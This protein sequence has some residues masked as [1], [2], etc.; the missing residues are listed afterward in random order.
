MNFELDEDQTMIEATVE[1]FVSDRYPPGVRE[2]ATKARADENWSLLAEL[3]ILAGLFSPEDGGL[4]GGS[5]EI[6]IILKTLGRGLVVE[7][8]LEQGLLAGGILAAG[9][10]EA[11][12]AEWLSPLLAGERRLGVAFTEPGGRWSLEPVET[13][14]EDARVNGTKSFASGDV[15]GWIVS[16]LDNRTPV[17]GLVRADDVGVTQRSY[18]RVDGAILAEIKFENAAVDRLPGALSSVEDALDRARLGATAEMVGLIDRVFASTLDYVRTRRQF[19]AAIGSFQAIQHR[20]ADLYGQI[21]LAR[22]QLLRAVTAAT[23]DRPCAIAA[24]KAQVSAVAIRTAEESI[25]LHGGMGASDELDIG[26]A[27]KR[28]LILST[29]LGDAA[30][31]VR[32]YNALMREAG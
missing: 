18:R 2:S 15:D 23:D 13:R 9:G 14:I 8:V 26:A 4:G 24:A 6:M 7:P 20:L 29:L 25:Q 30:H 10:S 19:G 3:G 5:T 16:A 22:S 12:K 11:Q 27:L 1:R 17:L 21:E 32:R 28:I 31:E